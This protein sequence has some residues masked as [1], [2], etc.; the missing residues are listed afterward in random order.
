M[1]DSVKKLQDYFNNTPEDQIQKDIEEIFG[2][3]EETDS[4]HIDEFL[5]QTWFIFENSFYCNFDFNFLSIPINSS[6]FLI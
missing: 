4:P 1:F 6:G 2:C 3:D 5:K